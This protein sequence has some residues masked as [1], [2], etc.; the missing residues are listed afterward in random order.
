MNT[1]SKKYSSA[2]E[3]Q[4]D[5]N[6]L[7]QYQSKLKSYCKMLTGN[8]WDGED[9]AHDTLLKIY[10]KYHKN[11]SAQQLSFN[12]MKVAAKN[13][14]LD[15]IK[16]VS[17]SCTTIEESREASYDPIESLPEVLTM[18]AIITA[19]ATEKEAAAFVLKEVFQYSMNE[20]S[21]ILSISEGAVKSTLFRIRQKLSSIDFNHS[22]RTDNVFYQIISA[23][24]MEQ[25]PEI[26]IEYLTRMKEE[27]VRVIG[28]PRTY[29]TSS[30]SP[31]MMAA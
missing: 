22:V 14:W 26:L 5:F 15:K 8:K 28:M 18:L 23:A 29:S 19:N 20:I 16:S 24:I 27:R 11:I 17:S 9:L 10:N 7:I 6:D 31:G 3:N 25:S 2:G 1:Q 4:F 21:E 12:L 13:R 30:H